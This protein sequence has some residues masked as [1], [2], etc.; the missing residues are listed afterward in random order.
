MMSYQCECLFTTSEEND[1]I[2]HLLEAF[3]PGP[4]DLGTD[5]QAHAELAGPGKRACSCGY[6][7][8]DL[9]AMDAH[10]LAA[11][12]TPG[13]TGTDGRKHSTALPAGHA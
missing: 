9:P 7:A 2:D 1:L 11:F 6:A 13:G 5:G 8:P 3:D 12:V 10:L 4:T